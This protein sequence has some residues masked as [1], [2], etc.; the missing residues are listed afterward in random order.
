MLSSARSCLVCQTNMFISCLQKERERG[1][2]RDRRQWPLPLL[3]NETNQLIFSRI[4]HR[5]WRKKN[6]NN[7]SF[8]KQTLSLKEKQ[9]ISSFFFSF[10]FCF[11]ISIYMEQRSEN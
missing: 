11:S 5:K 1:P 9:A 10:S 8:L 6:E 3:P 7:F 4:K 2:H